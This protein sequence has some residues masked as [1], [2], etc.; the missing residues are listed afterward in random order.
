MGA[1]KFFEKFAPACRTAQ[2]K[3]GGFISVRLAQIA[4][5]SAWGEA[6][7]KDIETGAESYNL[8]GVKGDGPA[9]HVRAWTW[10][11]VNGEN[12]RVI[13]NFRAYHSYDEHVVERDR[14]FEWS[15]YDAYRAAKTPEEAIHALCHAPAPYATDPAYEAKLLDIIAKYDLKRFDG[16]FADVRPDAWYAGDVA[17]LKSACI[18]SGDSNGNFRPNDA[19]TRAEAARLLRLVIRY[20]TGR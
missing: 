13:A 10:E 14:I 4:L 18:V 1:T 7:P 5:E 11:V 12:V 8:T 15:N 17:F 20:T 16:P 19:L 3:N 2:A 9:G 6:T